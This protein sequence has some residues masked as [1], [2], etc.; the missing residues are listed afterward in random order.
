MGLFS[1]GKKKARSLALIDIGSASVGGAYVHIEEG[2][3]PIIYYT[4]RVNVEPREGEEITDSMLRSLS[5]LERLL[6]E[7]GAPALRREAGDASIEQVL[8]SIA[9][10][11][12]ETR[13]STTH[14]QERKPFTFTRA[15]LEEAGAR[16]LPPD[17]DHV[18]S[19]QAVIATIL[20]GYETANPFG[21]RTTR[22]EMVILA[23]SIDRKV[24]H[25]LKTSLRRA[26]HTDAIELTAF[27]PV[28][29]AAFRDLYPH[30]DDFIVLDVSGCGTDVALVKRGLLT[31]VR[32]VAC[33]TH[34]LAQAARTAGKLAHASSGALLD[35]MVNQSFSK[36]SGAIERTW[37]DGMHEAFSSFASVQALPRTVFL[38]ADPDARDYLKRTLETSESRS[39]WLSDDPLSVIPVIPSHL[40]TRVKTRGLGEG[41]LFLALLALYASRKEEGAS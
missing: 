9:A 13:V 41:D 7:E 25:S 8:V 15:H 1:F 19:G 22:A 11:W 24:A 10:P 16:I 32:S 40:A 14:M 26:F 35:P 5:F 4:A 23:S 18:R 31:E 17:K 6:I 3:Q 29:Y 21:K 38:L 39:L 20:N 37:L 34:D 33:G 36:E 28:A 30:Q 27:A 2:T 12:Q